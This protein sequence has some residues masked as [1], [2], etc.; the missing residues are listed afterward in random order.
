M[1][2]HGTGGIALCYRKDAE[3][4][5]QRPQVLCARVKTEDLDSDA[6]QETGKWL[7]TDADR[8][9]GPLAESL[10]KA[11]ARNSEMRIYVPHLGWPR[12]D[13]RDDADWDSAMRDLSGIPGLVIGVSAIAR[14][15]E[16]PYPHFDVR[17]FAQRVL[18]L[19]PPERIVIG[20]DC[21]QAHYASYIKLAHHWVTSRWP[22]WNG[23]AS[24]GRAC[25]TP[26]SPP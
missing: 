7:L 8:G 20:T 21:P 1:S 4:V 12:R 17:R 26:T 10:I 14:F 13:Q 6:L 11:A 2:K 22:E 16:E 19:F 15:S 9:I 23:D 18:N 25:P 3:D 24:V 5:L